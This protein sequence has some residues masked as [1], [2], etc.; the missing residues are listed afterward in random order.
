MLL[1]TY[2]FFLIVK[3][4]FYNSVHYFSIMASKPKMCQHKIFSSDIYSYKA[5]KNNSYLYSYVLIYVYIDLHQP[6]LF[7]VQ[8]HEWI[9]SGGHDYF[10]IKRHNLKKG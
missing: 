6:N 1:L 2:S 9:L 5:V 7:L 8:R 3:E 10:F 4:N